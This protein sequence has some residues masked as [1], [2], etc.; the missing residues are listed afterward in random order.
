MCAVR[1]TQTVYEFIGGAIKEAR[2]RRGWSQE[3]LGS[4]LMRRRTHAAISDIE[5]GRTKLNVDELLEVAHLLQVNL[6]WLLDF[7][8][9]KVPVAMTWKEPAFDAY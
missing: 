4:M 6:W 5:R 8:T 7:D 1:S 2:V 3:Y 9:A